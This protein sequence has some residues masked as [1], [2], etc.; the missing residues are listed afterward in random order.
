MSGRLEARQRTRADKVGLSGWGQPSVRSTNLRIP[1]LS[2][3]PSCQNKKSLVLTEEMWGHRLKLKLP[4]AAAD[5]QPGNGRGH[6]YM[7]RTCTRDYQTTEIKIKRGGHKYLFPSNLLFRSFLPRQN[8]WSCYLFSTMWTRIRFR[9]YYKHSNDNKIVSAQNA[10]TT[11]QLNSSFSLT[12]RGYPNRIFNTRD[13]MM[14]TS[15]WSLVEF[16]S[17]R[18]GFQN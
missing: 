5:M 9:N 6:G 2:N 17:P 8:S 10:L 4:N 11:L 16:S 3:M 7:S 18:W 12:C 1:S 14:C 15:P 13:L